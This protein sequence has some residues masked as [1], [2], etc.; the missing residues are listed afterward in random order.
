MELFNIGKIEK[1]KGIFY[2]KFC[3]TRYYMQG[4][5]GEVVS[6]YAEF[7]FKKNIICD[8]K[9]FIDN[10]VYINAFGGLRLG[11]NISI[12]KGVKILTFKYNFSIKNIKSFDKDA[13]PDPVSIGDKVI[14]GYNSIILMGIK[15]GS[16]TIIGAGSVV[17]K[18]IPDNCI[19]AG[20]PA[21]IIKNIS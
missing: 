15:I 6:N 10:E 5:K 21:R 17:T 13:I 18:N 2:R 1:A 16:N 12:A 19:A 7:D 14:I 9:I 20:N 11:K 8:G 3:N 4:S